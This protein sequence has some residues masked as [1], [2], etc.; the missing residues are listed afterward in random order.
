MTTRLR[1]PA[2]FVLDWLHRRAGA[3]A[4]GGGGTIEA[5]LIR[6]YGPEGRPREASLELNDTALTDLITQAQHLTDPRHH[7]EYWMSSRGTVLS[8]RATLRRLRNLGIT[9]ERPHP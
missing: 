2:V 6:T 8:A 4:E 5:Q 3:Q 7:H 9:G 1:L